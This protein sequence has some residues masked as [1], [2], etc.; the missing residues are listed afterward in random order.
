MTTPKLPPP[1]R[2]AQNRSLVLPVAQPQQFPARGDDLGGDQV[3]AGQAV[4]AVEPAQPAAEGEPGDPGHGHHAEC[5]RQPE[6]LGGAGRTRPASARPRPGPSR[7]AVERERLHAGQVEQ[8]G[9]RRSTAFPAT[10]CPPPRT[11]S[12]SSCSPGERDAAGHVG[13]IRAADHRQRPPIDHG[14]EH[15]AGR[16]VAGVRGKQQ[17]SA[18]IRSESP[19]RRVRN[20]AHLRRH[21]A[22]PRAPRAGVPPRSA[23]G[24]APLARR[25]PSSRRSSSPPRSGSRRSRAR[26]PS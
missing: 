21:R 10:L 4:A 12:G 3:V 23:Y 13:G 26:A 18:Q 8:Q 9:R 11:E 20:P 17:G 15:G 24:D 2:T 6:R 5:R 7:S 14:V 19:Q 22:P 25:R 1:P 16:V